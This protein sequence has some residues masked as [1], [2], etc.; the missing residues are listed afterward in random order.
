[1]IRNNLF[2]F[3]KTKKIDLLLINQVCVSSI[4]SLKHTN[5]LVKLDCLLSEKKHE[6]RNPANY[7]KL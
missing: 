5:L 2:F 6:Y 1:M 7:F 3:R 4:Q